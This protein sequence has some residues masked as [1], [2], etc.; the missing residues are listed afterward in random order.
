MPVWVDHTKRF[1]YL[2]FI[3]AIISTYFLVKP[4][5]S[6]IVLAIIT[7]LL[8]Q[9]VYKLWHKTFKGRD[10]IATPFSILT[11][12]L[13]FLLPVATLV[14]ITVNQAVDF[15]RQV[16]SVISTENVSLEILIEEAND[17]INT[18][19]YGSYELTEENLAENIKNVIEPVGG[20]IIEKAPSILTLST[21]LI[22]QLIV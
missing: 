1:F 13:T 20:Y 3:L 12:L 8:F 2:V 11:V 14:V 19:P 17:F 16:N 7:V 21:E 10:S 6:V 18:F 5:L 9:P 22:T 15:Y 4:Y